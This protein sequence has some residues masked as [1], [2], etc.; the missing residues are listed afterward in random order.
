MAQLGIP[1]AAMA[2]SQDGKVVFEGGMGVKTLGQSD[3]VDANT[4]FM[5]ASNT[6]GMAT[7]LLATLV[8]DG[9][10]KWDQPVTQVYPTFRLGD[11]ATTSSTLVKHLSA[12]VPGC[13]ARTWNG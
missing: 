1:G 3:P 2:L 5:V 4:V 6:K 11:D 9:K 13:R 8:D 10:L 7:L 12:R